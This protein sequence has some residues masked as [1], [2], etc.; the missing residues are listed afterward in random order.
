V[1]GK[2]V[3]FARP[4]KSGILSRIVGGLVAVI[5]TDEEWAS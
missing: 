5:V 2:I 1:S 3:R 4:V